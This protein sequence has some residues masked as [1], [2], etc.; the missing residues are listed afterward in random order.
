MVIN[1]YLKYPK[2]KQT[3]PSG[4]YESRQR[5]PY[6]AGGGQR[7]AVISPIHHIVGGETA[8]VVH[9]IGR[10]SDRSFIMAGVKVY[11]PIID[12]GA[13]ICREHVSKNRV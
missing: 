10:P 8:P 1:N 12:H 11:S 2:L 4:G 5:N 7:G 13:G 6:I 3:R 9:H